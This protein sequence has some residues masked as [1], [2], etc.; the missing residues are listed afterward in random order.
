[1][2]YTVI[3]QGDITKSS[4]KLIDDTK[5]KVFMPVSIDDKGIAFSRRYHFDRLIGDHN[6][7]NQAMPD[8]NYNQLHLKFDLPSDLAS[9]EKVM[10]LSTIIDKF[11]TIDGIVFGYVDCVDN[12]R[13][14]KLYGSLSCYIYYDIISDDIVRSSVEPIIKQ[15]LSDQCINNIDVSINIT[16]NSD[17]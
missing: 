3:L 16:D 15:A 11:A 9:S 2:K 4:F 1:M 12:I 13:S 8:R 7:I 10:V 6:D 17:K 5:E 14:N